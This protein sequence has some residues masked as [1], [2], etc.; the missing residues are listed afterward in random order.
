MNESEGRKAKDKKKKTRKKRKETEKERN[1]KKQC[2]ADKP[3]Q[4]ADLYVL[5]GWSEPDL[6][7]KFAAPIEDERMLGSVRSSREVCSVQE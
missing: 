5:S 6:M 7:T 1:G 4:E 2:H 3:T